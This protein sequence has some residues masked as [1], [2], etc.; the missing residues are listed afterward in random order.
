M[1][2]LLLIVLLLGCKK[3][4]PADPQKIT[5]QMMKG[6]GDVLLRFNGIT[7]DFADVENFCSE[8]EYHKGQTYWIKTTAKE[9]EVFIL[10]DGKQVAKGIGEV[11]YP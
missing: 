4:K 11:S 6:R 2:Y 7:T 8:A 5:F 10:L 3:D 1:R 9:G